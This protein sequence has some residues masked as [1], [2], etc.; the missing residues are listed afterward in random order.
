[1][2]RYGT[3]LSQESLQGAGKMEVEVSVM[4]LQVKEFKQSS[5]ETVFASG[6]LE[7][8]GPTTLGF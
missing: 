1:M 4:Q 3:C 7:R 8:C 5:L 2:A 6:V